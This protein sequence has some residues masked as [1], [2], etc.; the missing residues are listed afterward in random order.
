MN[1]FHLDHPR[2][3]GPSDDGCS[4]PFGKNNAHNITMKTALFDYFV[5]FIM[6][7][8]MAFLIHL[9]Q[10]PGAAF[11]FA[12]SLPLLLS[13]AIHLHRSLK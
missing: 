6:N 11:V 2:P 5:Y 3:A 4:I 12:M 8:V 9:H 1:G 13:F 10:W 7:A